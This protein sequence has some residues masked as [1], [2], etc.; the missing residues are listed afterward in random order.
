V[1]LRAEV[2]ADK[3]ASHPHRPSIEALTM[4]AT[5]W[6]MTHPRW[7]ARALR[8][9][10]L[11]RLVARRHDRIRHLPPPLSAW[12]DARDLP[13]PPAE[14]FRDQWVRERGGTP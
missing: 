11:G 8:L 1:H 6:T 12:T 9:G 4:K 7:W 14:T 5:S 3:A 10:R 13:R 2:V